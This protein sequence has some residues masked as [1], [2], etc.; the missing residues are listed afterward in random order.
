MKNKDERENKVNK[1]FVIAAIVV[2]VIF[3]ILTIVSPEFRA[4]VIQ[5]L[6]HTVI[7]FP[8]VIVGGNI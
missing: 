7:L 4:I 6:K 8:P 1:W 2:C 3:A 5:T